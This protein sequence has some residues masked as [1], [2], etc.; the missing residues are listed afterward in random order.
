MNPRIRKFRQESASFTAFMLSVSEPQQG[1]PV[2]RL[3][4]LNRS[5]EAEREIIK[6]ERSVKVESI[7]IHSLLFK[8]FINTI[9]L[10][11][12]F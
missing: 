11:E 8:K 3:E 1:K 6:K 7:R 10:L 2:R 5:V 9:H 12:Y 4:R